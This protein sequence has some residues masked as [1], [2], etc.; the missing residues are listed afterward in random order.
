M[1]PIFAL[2]KQAKKHASCTTP[3]AKRIKKSWG[4]MLKQNKNKTLEKMIKKILY[5]NIYLTVMI[6]VTVV[7]VM[8]KK[9]RRRKNIILKKG[10]KFIQKQ[11]IPSYIFNEKESLI[12]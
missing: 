3:L 11:Q 6:N 8:L 10:K 12:A 9:L 4:A 1:K 5:Q 2:E 7:S